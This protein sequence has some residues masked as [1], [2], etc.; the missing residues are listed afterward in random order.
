LGCF[1]ASVL[2]EQGLAVS[3]PVLPRTVWNS[4]P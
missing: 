1:G 2:L 4:G 3:W